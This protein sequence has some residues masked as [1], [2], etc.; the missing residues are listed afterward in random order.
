MDS[1][2]T[3][4]VLYTSYVLLVKILQPLSHTGEPNE[5]TKKQPSETNI[6]HYTYEKFLRI[7]VC[8]RTSTYPGPSRRKL[9][10]SYDAYASNSPSTSSKPF[11]NYRGKTFFGSSRPNA[12]TNRLEILQEDSPRA[13]LLAVQ[14]S[15][16]SDIG[17]TSS[18]ASP[19]FA[20][21]RGLKL[22]R[23]S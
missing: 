3:H 9:C 17:N 11:D 6:L 22:N 7:Q 19:F 13:S 18:T 5:R 16:R 14:F 1:C 8:K 21:F 4:L 20:L 15:P 2:S 23:D 12:S 10:T